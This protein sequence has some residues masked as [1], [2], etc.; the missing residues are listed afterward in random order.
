MAP[1]K[2]PVFLS[3]KPST[4]NRMIRPAILFLAWHI[5]SRRYYRI[6]PR[7][8]G[9]ARRAYRQVHVRHETLRLISLRYQ[10]QTRQV[11]SGTASAYTD[12]L[13]LA[14]TAPAERHCQPVLAPMLGLFRDTGE[15]DQKASVDAGHCNCTTLTRRVVDFGVQTQ[16]Q[17]RR[18]A[19]IP[20]SRALARPCCGRSTHVRLNHPTCSLPGPACTHDRHRPPNRV[21]AY[22]DPIPRERSA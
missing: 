3:Q 6:L 16:A 13:V 2:I 11:F 18:P 20:P 8:K 15:Q 14:G 7:P 21:T 17:G 1:T 22:S 19:R 12:I 4:K 9:G 5:S 10:K